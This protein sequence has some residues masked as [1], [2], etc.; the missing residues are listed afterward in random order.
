MKDLI[1]TKPNDNIKAEARNLLNRLQKYTV[2]RINAKPCAHK[3][4]IRENKLK[5]PETKY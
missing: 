5:P 4:S 3:S 2:F 1:K